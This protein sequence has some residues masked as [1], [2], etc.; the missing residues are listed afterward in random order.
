MSDIVN[1]EM[2]IVA[3]TTDVQI[4]VVILVAV[5][6]Y[7]EFYPLAYPA[8]PPVA[9]MNVAHAVIGRTDS[10]DCGWEVSIL[11]QWRRLVDGTILVL[12]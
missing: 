7:F 11:S 5:F 3:S 4:I 1:I 8:D 6:A 12:I 9:E 10:L 2:I